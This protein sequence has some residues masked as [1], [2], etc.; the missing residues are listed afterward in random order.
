MSE[1]CAPPEEHAHHE[2]HWL[3]NPDRD[4]VEPLEWDRAIRMYWRIARSRHPVAL[5]EEGWR[6]I[7]P[8]LPP[9]ASEPA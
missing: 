7:A 6:Y 3:Y 2:W 9:P 5:Y 1:T 4:R 8:C